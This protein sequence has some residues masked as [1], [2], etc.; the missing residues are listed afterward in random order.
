MGHHCH[1]FKLTQ[2]YQNFLTGRNE[3]ISKIKSQ[4][5]FLQKSYNLNFVWWKVKVR[6]LRIMHVAS[7]DIG[8]IQRRVKSGIM[9]FPQNSVQTLWCDCKS[10][11]SFLVFGSDIP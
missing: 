10:I 4:K 8:E 11:T 5:L 9:I 7:H 2:L 6:W 1:F 3:N